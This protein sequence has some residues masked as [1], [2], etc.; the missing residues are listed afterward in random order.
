MKRALLIAL[1]LVISVAFVGVV[2]A[3]PHRHRRK[4]LL[5]RLR[6]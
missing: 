1:T 6:K 2:F 5:Q 3:Q 4:L